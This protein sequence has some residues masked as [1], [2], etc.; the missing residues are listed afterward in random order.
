MQCFLISGPTGNRTRP[1]SM[2]WRRNTDLLWAQF[3]YLFI[4]LV[5]GKKFK[6]KA[7][8]WVRH[9]AVTKSW[10]NVGWNYLPNMKQWKSIPQQSAASVQPA[11]KNIFFNSF[12]IMENLHF[13]DYFARKSLA[14][15][16]QE[17]FL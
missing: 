11:K 5:F 17:R 10:L 1:S 3:L 6:K 4:L 16:P 9:L 12:P 15:G 2:P 8:V 7:E 14:L 13:G